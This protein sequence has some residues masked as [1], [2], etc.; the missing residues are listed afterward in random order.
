MEKAAVVEL[1][2]EIAQHA[3]RKNLD[4]AM[5]L[6]HKAEGAGSA[7]SHTYAAAIN[8]NIRCGS[9][10]GAAELF[11]KL[12]QSRTVRLDVITCT[13]MM[14]GYCGDGNTHN[15]M[16][17]LDLMHAA[18]PPVRPNVRTINTLLRGCV[19]TGDVEAAEALVARM[20]KDFH[21]APDI[22]TWEYLLALLCQALR[23]EKAL[24]IVG[25][26]KADPALAGEL[27]YSYVAVARAAALLADWKN[28]RK[29]LRSAAE[30]IDTG[31]KQE[32]EEEGAAGAGGDD[33]GDEEGDGDDDDGVGDDDDKPLPRGAKAPARRQVTGGKK[34]WKSPATNDGG[35]DTRAQSLAVF[36]RHKRAEL[37]QEIQVI[38]GYVARHTA[39][40]PPAGGGKGNAAGAAAGK[41]GGGAAKGSDAAT[42]SLP[43]LLPLFTRVFSFSSP[44]AAVPFIGPAPAVA[45]ARTALVEELLRA[46][47]VRFGLD[48]TLQRVAEATAATATATA[49]ATTAAAGGEEASANPAAAEAE[50]KPRGPAPGSKKSEKLEKAKRKAAAEG[51][52]ASLAARVA[53]LTDVY[54]AAFEA[55][56]DAQGY[57]A[58][59][60]AFAQARRVD[61]A[62]RAALAA[63]AD[64]DDDD[65]Q[66]GSR[67][68]AKR[69]NSEGDGA[70]AAAAV[71]EAVARP[72]KL[73]ICSGAGEW[74]VEQ[75]RPPFAPQHRRCPSI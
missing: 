14:K 67:K 58:I 54:R 12:R 11:E 7:N 2:K 1:N 31:E 68:K 24:P 30:A 40:V 45:A 21:V 36:R 27:G 25:R 3:S 42:P 20:Q 55:C 52:A 37:R 63:G 10:A 38:E 60:E 33:V 44:A 56:V 17:I 64:G 35:D 61:G 15:A 13:T 22:S 57:V 71:A 69:S 53:A 72:V 48:V 74:A 29:A 75:V 34:A 32:E 18:R 47:R 59:P 28:C 41:A 23:L 50:G 73:E 19:Q 8:A 43:A 4:A 66:G 6:F 62:V 16:A 39:P 46:A 49:T 51:R 70:A 9:M 65:E 26:L 5:A